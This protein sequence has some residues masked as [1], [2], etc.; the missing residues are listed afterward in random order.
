MND[1]PSLP[2]L[3]DAV[4]GELQELMGAN[5]GELVAVFLDNLPTQLDA[6]ETALMQDD[7]AALACSAHQFKS[8]SSSIGARQLAEWAQQLEML[9]RNGT[10]AE[11]A[12]LL[13]RLTTCVEHTRRAL[14]KLPST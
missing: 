1:Y 7:P 3:D 8:G 4:V 9:G 10:T 6:I 11:A 5:F 14:R 13:E 12:V 2:L